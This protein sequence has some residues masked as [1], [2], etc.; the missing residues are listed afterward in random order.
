MFAAAT[1]PVPGSGFVNDGGAAYR[2]AE[3]AGEASVIGRLAA[4][5][6]A[7]GLVVGLIALVIGDAL[8]ATLALIVA[9][10]APWFGL[11]WMLHSQRRVFVAEPERQAK[12]PHMRVHLPSSGY[13]I[14]FPVR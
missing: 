14:R 12:R 2:Q 1:P 8:V 9:V 11:A 3:E 10:T 6:W 7:V 5:T 13:R 4:A